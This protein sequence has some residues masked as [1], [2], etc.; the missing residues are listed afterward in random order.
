MF[1]TTLVNRKN[2]QLGFTLIEIMVVVVIIG[3][4][5]T[6]I[7]PRVLGRLDQSQQIAAQA[8][9]NQLSTALKFYKLDNAKYPSSGDG[10]GV[11][12]SGSKDGKGYL[13][14]NSL[15]K[16]P[17]GNDYLYQYPGQ[18][19]EFDIWSLGAD[20]QQGGDEVNADIG[21]WNMDQFK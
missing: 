19:L 3:M 8:D 16:D 9:I 13:D 5:A 7:L 18:H 10:L 14:G 17:W 11:L 6:M 12:L 2:L 1:R 20:G 4:L 21:N 15:P